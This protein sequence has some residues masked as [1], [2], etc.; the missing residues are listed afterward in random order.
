MEKIFGDKAKFAIEIKIESKV[1]KSNLR[2][3]IGNKG[4]GYFKRN[5]KLIYSVQSLKKIISN[6]HLLCESELLKMSPE[7]IFTWTL[8]KDL[9]EAQTSESNLEFDRRREYV[10]F[11]GDQLDE[12]ST[13][14]YFHNSEFKWTIYDVKKRKVLS[15]STSEEDFIP[16]AMEYINWYELVYGDL[17]A[18]LD[19]LARE[20]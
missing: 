17:N 9:V 19:G 2:V 15:F 5:G 13:M 12:F 4:L 7:E 11:W 1:E 10:V 8:G 18:N 20:N 3:W 16:V 14:C 6:R